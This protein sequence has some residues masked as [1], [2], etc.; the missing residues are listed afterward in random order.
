RLLR[1]VHPLDHVVEVG[2]GGEELLAPGGAEVLAHL[3][4]DQAVEPVPQ[5][6]GRLLALE[7]IEPGFE[8]LDLVAL[9]FSCHVRSLLS[10]P[11]AGR[12]R[13]WRRRPA[14]LPA[15][16]AGAGCAGSGRPESPAPRPLRAARGP[17]ARSAAPTSPGHTRRRRGRSRRSCRD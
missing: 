11:A 7:A 1:L 4:R 3:A 5:A 2:P 15:C 16:G 6:L 8:L 10:E 12:R 17:A 9:L 13:A 14:D